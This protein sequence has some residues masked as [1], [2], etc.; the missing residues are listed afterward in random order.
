MVKHNRRELQQFLAQ[1]GVY[2]TIIWQ[3]PD[4][5]VNKLNMESKWIYDTI[6]CVPCDQR[7]T[8]D[9]MVFI[10]EL[11]DRFEKTEGIMK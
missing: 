8:V 11:F 10:G 6:L 4:E 9:D 2:A 1:N 5:F 7:Y 3:C